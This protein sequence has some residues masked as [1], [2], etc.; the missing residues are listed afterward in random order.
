[1]GVSNREPIDLTILVV[2]QAQL[3]E[4][5]GLDMEAHTNFF[6]HSLCC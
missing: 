4:S 2:L 5:Y 6:V 3:E 1:M